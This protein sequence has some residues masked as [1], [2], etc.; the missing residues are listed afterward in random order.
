MSS[1]MNDLA[2]AGGA[3][4]VLLGLFPGLAAALALGF[5]VGAG[6]SLA[7]PI[8]LVAAAGYLLAKMGGW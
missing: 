5:G 2:L 1:I 6:A 4:L 3:A 7:R 8:L